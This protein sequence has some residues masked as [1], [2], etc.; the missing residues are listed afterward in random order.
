MMP[1]KHMKN[2]DELMAE[3][4][5][6][7]PNYSGSPVATLPEH[8]EDDPDV[9]IVS[10]EHWERQQAESMEWAKKLDIGNPHQAV[11]PDGG[12]IYHGG[13]HGCT[14]DAIQCPRCQYMEAD[15]SLPN[16]NPRYK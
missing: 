2:V 14:T 1:K 4:T 7:E 15:W 8:P 16:L 9:T 12:H 10:W 6:I 5:A 3:H 13:C 11:R